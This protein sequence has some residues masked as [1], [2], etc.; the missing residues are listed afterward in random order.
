MVNRVVPGKKLYRLIVLSPLIAL[1]VVCYS[2]VEITW[3]NGTTPPAP[4]PSS[5]SLTLSSADRLGRT[6]VDDDDTADSIIRL[7]VPSDPS[8]VASVWRQLFNASDSHSPLKTCTPTCQLEVRRI[9][10]DSDRPR[11]NQEQPH[12]SSWLLQSLD[13][14]GRRKDVGG[15]EYYVAFYDNQFLRPTDSSNFSN[16]NHDQQYYGMA[17]HV[18]N[19]EDLGNGQYSLIFSTTPSIQTL[20]ILAGG[21]S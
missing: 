9:S 20:S 6:V 5:S 19:M 10:P 12:H 16:G 21:E 1:I 13:E 3:I 14:H 17:T 8:E 2:I 4:L 11:H 15:D 7:R 18:A